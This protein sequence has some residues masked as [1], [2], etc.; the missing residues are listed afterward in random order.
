M[1]IRL[2]SAV[3]GI[4]FLV[5][6]CAEKAPD[7]EGQKT[8]DPVI[9]TLM[10]NRGQAGQPLKV[11]GKYLGG[12]QG[13]AKVFFNSQSVESTATSETEIAITIPDMSGK[14]AVQVEVS[15]KKS[16]ILYFEY[17]EQETD[18]AQADKDRIKTWIEHTD[19]LVWVFTGNSITQGAKH[20]HGLRPYSEIFSERVRFEIN[21]PRDYVINTA[22]SG[23]TL[24][25]ILDDFDHRV[26]QFEPKIVFLMIGTNDAATNNNTSVDQYA[27]RL[28]TF[29]PRVRSLGAVPV[30]LTPTWIRTDL[31]PERATLS[32][33]A[34]KMKEIAKN[35]QVILVDN[36]SIWTS[37][38]VT[39]YN[40]GVS[41]DLLNDPLHPNGR[42]HK[43][44]A[45]S[46][47]RELG[48]FDPDQPTGGAPYYEGE[49]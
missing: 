42:G 35:Q 25:N 9:T 26:A 48:I 43:E 15:G 29:I 14:V 24:K 23:N 32:A 11:I 44:I 49:H 16:N 6:S 40:G 18:P 2:L 8:A 10:P 31:A 27:E 20:T 17:L 22:I 30:L 1:K 36:W 12:H 38:L 13:K 4:V 47:F 45:M 34:S 21:R 41:H 37:E 19:P 46:L 33:Y 5:L 39:K 3:S 28:G 7:S